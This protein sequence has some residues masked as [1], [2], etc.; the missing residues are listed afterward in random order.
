MT[1]K[2]RSKQKSDAQTA[3]K[4]RESAQGEAEQSNQFKRLAV[5]APVRVSRLDSF[6]TGTVKMT[7]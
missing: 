2:T 6:V 5:G 3:S 4:G 7:P 1:K